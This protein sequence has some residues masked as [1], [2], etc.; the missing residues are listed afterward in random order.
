MNHSSVCRAAPG[1]PGSAK[2][3]KQMS[4]IPGHFVRIIDNIFFSN[5]VNCLASKTPNDENGAFFLI[6]V[7]A[8]C[9]G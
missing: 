5:S 9:Y 3:I 7:M 2:D 4:P 8:F 1:S 6:Y